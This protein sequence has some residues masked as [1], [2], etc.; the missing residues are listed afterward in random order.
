MDGSDGE[1][2]E[3][4][5]KIISDSVIENEQDKVSSSELLIMLENVLRVL[6]PI[7]LIIGLALILK[8]KRSKMNNF[9]HRMNFSN[10]TLMQH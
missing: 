4:S 10:E 7:L 8:R 1:S 6:V 3:D 2:L 5:S 9:C